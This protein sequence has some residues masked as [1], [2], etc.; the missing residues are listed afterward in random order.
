MLHSREWLVVRFWDPFAET[1]PDR[2]EVPPT[3]HCTGVEPQFG[4]LF[5]L[6]NLFRAQ[7]A[8]AFF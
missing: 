5:Q 1:V 2:V 3:A 6:L 4:F 8:E 7:T